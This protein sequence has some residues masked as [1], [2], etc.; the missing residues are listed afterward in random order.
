[1]F[2]KA[3][4]GKMSQ[5]VLQNNYLHLYVILAAFSLMVFRYYWLI[6]WRPDEMWYCM[7]VDSPYFE[8]SAYFR[9]FNFYAAKLIGY[10]LGGLNSFE[11]CMAVSLMYSLGIISCAYYIILKLSGKTSAILGAILVGTYSTMIYQAT[12]F[13][14]DRACLFFGLLAIA[15]AV[16]DNKD[17][18]I[19]FCL[20]GFFLL[21]AIYSKRPALC[22]ILPIL[23]VLF[24]H[25]TWK[26]YLYL[27]LGMAA[28]LLFIAVCDYI[29]LGDF[30]WHININNYTDFMSWFS[31]RVDQARVKSSHG[32]SWSKTYFEELLNYEFIHILFCAVA[33][34]VLLA[35]DMGK[36]LNRKNSIAFAIILVGIS[37]V[38]LHE[39]FHAW[40]TKLGIYPRYMLTM[41]IPLLIAFTIMLPI[42]K[43]DFWEGSKRQI[44]RYADLLLILFFVFLF[45]YTRHYNY[46]LLKH[47]W[48]VFNSLLHVFSFWALLT[49]TGGLLFC[50]VW[51]GQKL[52]VSQLNLAKY[53]GLFCLMVISGYSI[54][55]GNNY[56]HK[57]VQTGKKRI[58]AKYTNFIKSYNGRFEKIMMYE[59]PKKR[60]KYIRDV[61][62]IFNYLYLTGKLK[63]EEYTDNSHIQERHLKDILSPQFEYLMTKHKEKQI[64]ELVAE[65]GIG[66]EKIWN[67]RKVF[68]YR[69]LS[70][71]V[72]P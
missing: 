23:I 28:C 55:W 71:D 18:W 15:L 59:L 4:P 24:Y 10:F 3:G 51:M 52:K 46:G 41:D 38:V 56:S 27:T 49:A 12:W 30:F 5:S 60:N 53:V 50:G 33:S 54:I 34:M 14:S 35:L 29:W 25:R 63:K 48:G 70:E 1:M 43:F 20:S 2:Y 19:R 65:Y 42:D 17:N 21:G 7:Q 39:A 9:F 40:Q 67:F 57:H 32:V 68:L 8:K 58:E 6:Q 36:G 62:M 69:K 13:G 45:F 72:S 64:N 31:G 16:C 11:K 66:L 61:R 44:H 22:F 26:V 47:H 37:S